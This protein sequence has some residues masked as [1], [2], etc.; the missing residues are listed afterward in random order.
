MKKSIFL[1]TLM[2]LFSSAF[3]TAQVTIGSNND[4]NAT[5]DVVASAT[6][7]STAE[8]IIAPRLTGDQIKGKDARYGTAQRGAIVYATSAVGTTSTKTVNIKAEGYYYF[9][10]AVW[11]ALKSEGAAAPAFIVSAEITSSTYTVT[12]EDYLRFKPTALPVQVTLPTNAPVGKV[13]YISNT[14][15]KD[16]NFSPSVLYNNSFAGVG[17][18]DSKVLVHLGNNLWDFVSGW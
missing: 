17:A 18:G 15:T 5:L 2:L 12:N 9:D 11:Q 4:P 14:G 8:G 10:G 6:D 7:G 1:A 16:A 13:I 3:L